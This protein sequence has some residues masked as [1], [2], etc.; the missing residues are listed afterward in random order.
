MTSKYRD[1]EELVF[2]IFYELFYPKLSL[3][4]RKK[5][6]RGVEFFGTWRKRQ[7]TKANKRHTLSVSL[8]FIV[9]SDL[10]KPL[11]ISRDWGYYCCASPLPSHNPALFLQTVADQTLSVYDIIAIPI[12][13]LL[14]VDIIFI[15]AMQFEKVE[16]N[17]QL[18]T[19]L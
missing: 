4:V 11:L 19:Y 13:G 15:L 14:L 10:F 17:P 3:S 7:Q 16:V 12:K 18:Q 1:V 6:D 8:F 5:L 2:Q 9:P